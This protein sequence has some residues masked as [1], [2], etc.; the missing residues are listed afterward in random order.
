MGQGTLP[1]RVEQGTL[2]RR[3]GQGSLPRRVGQGTLPRRV[4]Q[5]TLPR[6][7]VR[8]VWGRARAP[9]LTRSLLCLLT[10][11]LLYLL[12]RSQLPVVRGGE[13]KPTSVECYRCLSIQWVRL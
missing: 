4:G 9:R 1:R 5:G 13:K 10:R 2:P 12:T 7:G 11:S 6:R 3:V 8:D